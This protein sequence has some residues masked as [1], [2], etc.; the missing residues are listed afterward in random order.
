MDANIVTHL[1]PLQIASELSSLTKIWYKSFNSLNA[2]P[3]GKEG[4]DEVVDFFHR[5][6]IIIFSFHPSHHFK[7]FLTKL[8]SHYRASG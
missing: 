4:L 3:I 6:Y 5:V 8:Q 1:Y 2:Q 7:Q